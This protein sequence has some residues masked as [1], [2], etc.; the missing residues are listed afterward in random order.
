MAKPI[1]DPR[2][3]AFIRKLP[4]CI[5]HSERGIEAAHVG[6]HG[7]AQKASD[8]S[9]IPLCPR[10]HRTGADSLHALGPR[11]FEAAHGVLLAELVNRLNEKPRIFLVEGRFYTRIRE[12]EYL[13]G[14]VAIGAAR[15][16][17]CAQDRW[18]RAYV[19]EM[20]S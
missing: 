9:T 2:Y 5:C 15:A 4:C 14:R 7:M 19:E 8:R 10:H 17:A 11:Q 18:R 3:L 16:I 20:A 1:R 12:R 13:L 6:P